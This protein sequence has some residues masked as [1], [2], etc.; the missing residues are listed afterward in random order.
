MKQAWGIQRKKLAEAKEIG[1][2]VPREER[3][4]VARELKKAHFSL[5]ND[6]NFIRSCNQDQFRGHEVTA[7]PA[8]NDEMSSK[9]RRTNFKLGTNA[10]FYRETTAAKDFGDKQPRGTQAQNG[11]RA[12]VGAAHFAL[13]FSANRYETT[14]GETFDTAK[15]KEAEVA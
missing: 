14:T 6:A 4:E 15:Q 10:T 9:I 12:E 7:S 11:L 8:R 3:K 13:G 2:F 5:G 1:H